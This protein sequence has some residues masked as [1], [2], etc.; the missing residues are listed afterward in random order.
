M[1]PVSRMTT[2]VVRL[3]AV[4]AV[5]MGATYSTVAPTIAVRAQS[6]LPASCA[7]TRAW[8][9]VSSTVSCVC[10]KFQAIRKLW[11][12]IS[13]STDVLIPVLSARAEEPFLAD[14][15][16][17]PYTRVRFLDWTYYRIEHLGWHQTEMDHSH[18]TPCQ[19]QQ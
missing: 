17:L 12:R 2:S 7:R 18:I 5:G 16:H 6:N 19:Q 13:S 15:G 11:I 10:R 8:H 3:P 9:H 14:V 1:C 4:D